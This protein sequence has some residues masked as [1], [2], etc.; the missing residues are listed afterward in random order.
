M[1][2]TILVIEDDAAIRR[3]ILDAL[4]FEGYDTIE[5]ENG[6]VGLESA[7]QRRYDL[8]LL[9]LVL[10]G[11]DGLEI[12]REVRALYPTQPVIILTAR[13]EETDRVKGL[14]MGADDYVVKPFSV[15]E[16]LA[17]VEAVLR[18]SPERPVSR[19]EIQLA[20]ASADLANGVIR[21]KDGE[22]RELSE[23]ETQL[24][25]YLTHN[26]GRV[27]SR[28]EILA[29]VWQI[30]PHGIETRTIDMHIARLREKLRDD[31]SHPRLIETVRG[32]GYRFADVEVSS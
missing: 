31:P 20:H 6:N 7:L 19:L 26:A 1:K 13:G 21:F 8:L 9:D 24:L 14:K 4:R 27:I 5:S 32:K 3:G 23:R 25:R 17:R 16:L 11:R 18:R 28:E 22:Q 15:K 12:L 2:Q 30:N 29:H 10:P